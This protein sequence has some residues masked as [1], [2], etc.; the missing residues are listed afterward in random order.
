MEEEGQVK[1]ELEEE[2]D[3]KKKNKKKKIEE[4]YFKVETKSSRVESSLVLG[5]GRVRARDSSVRRTGWEG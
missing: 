4:M 3:L 1:E 5:E 2:K